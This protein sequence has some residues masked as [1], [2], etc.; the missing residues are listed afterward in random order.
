[1]FDFNV[2]HIED[3]QG[4][5]IALTGMI[6]VFCV[7]TMISVFIVFLPKILAIVAQKYPE[8]EMHSEQTPEEDDGPLLA[9]LG[10][11]LHQRDKGGI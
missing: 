1:M 4:I 2:Q 5:A 3:G 9:A 11:V 8:Q 6:I 10:F 7:L